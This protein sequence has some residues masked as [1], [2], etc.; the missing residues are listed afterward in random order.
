MTLRA[1]VGEPLCGHFLNKKQKEMGPGQVR[2]LAV[3]CTTLS[4]AS[5][6]GPRRYYARCQDK[7]IEKIKVIIHE[8]QYA[9]GLH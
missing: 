9:C 7:V 1:D 6:E 2:S 4:Q 5:H 8:N 3:K